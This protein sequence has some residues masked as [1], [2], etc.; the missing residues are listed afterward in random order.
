MAL[1]KYYQHHVAG[2]DL[3]E[4]SYPQIP[5]ADLEKGVEGVTPSVLAR[6]I[7]NWSNGCVY[8]CQLCNDS[9]PITTRRDSFESHL[10]FKH[11]LT[12][13]QYTDQFGR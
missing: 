1:T 7:E 13:D 2:V 9:F 5:A 10:Y 6:E 8:Q 11:G 3:A 12:A 4:S